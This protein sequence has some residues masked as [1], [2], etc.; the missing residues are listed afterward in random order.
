MDPMNDN[1]FNYEK[2][3]SAFAEKDMIVFTIATYGYRSLVDNLIYSI[4]ANT[5][6]MNKFVVFSFDKKL[7]Q[8]LRKKHTSPLNIVHLPFSIMGS[9]SHL[10]APVEF[11]ARMWDEINLYKLHVFWHLFHQDFQQNMNYFYVDPDVYFYQS[12]GWF[13]EQ[14]ASSD[15][16]MVM[17]E[18]RPYCAGLMYVRKNPFTMKVFDPKNWKKCRTDDQTYIRKFIEDYH[19]WEKQES[20]KGND[21]YHLKMQVFPQDKFPNGLAFKEFKEER[22]MQYLKQK[23]FLAFHF[24]HIRGLDTK[25]TMM[26]KY[27]AWLKPMKIVNVPEKFQRDVNKICLEK[28]NSTYPGHQNETPQ[29]EL[30][31]HQFLRN[32]LKDMRIVS[33]YH[34]LPIYWTAVAVEKDPKLITECR[35]YVNRLLK[36]DEDQKYW[37]VVQHCKGLSACGIHVNPKRVQIFGTTKPDNTSNEL[38]QKGVRFGSGGKTTS[39]HQIKPV[40]KE[41]LTMVIPLLCAPHNPPQNS[42]K[43]LWKREVLASFVGNLSTHPIRERMQK[44]L[45]GV[46]GVVIENGKYNDENDMHRFREIMSKSMFALCPR[47]VGST[48]F[49]IAEA[50]EYGCIPVYISDIFSLPFSKQINWDNVCLKFPSKDMRKIHKNLLQKSKDM[51][52][53]HTRTQAINNV[54]ESYYKMDACSETILSKFLPPS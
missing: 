36:Q 17:Q 10:K 44:I 19:S 14:L 2:V 35:E 53:L 33:D 12:P 43:P 40:S 24:N 15:T 13:L 8:Y 31:F 1:E 26:K 4:E 46:E 7:C 42:L 3:H 5:E 29:I 9:R 34:Y 50:L 51:K 22:L 11:K 54:Y 52:W 38:V 39:S 41:H 45:G 21:P 23:R 18:D 20:K 47:G 37:T 30:Y 32:K 49:R 25:I 6:M 48:S 28:R 16:S 27:D